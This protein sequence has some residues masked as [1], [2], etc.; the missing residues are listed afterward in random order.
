VS[1]GEDRARAREWLERQIEELGDLRNANPRDPSFK[2]WRQNTL[3]VLQRIWP[4]EQYRSERFRRITFSP[5]STKPAGQLVRDWFT[6]GCTEATEYLRSLIEE[7]D[8]V[9]TP[10]P[11]D[12]QS[13]APFVGA[14][15]DDDDERMLDLGTNAAAPAPGA[16]GTSPA[17]SIEDNVLDLGAP[18]SA[19]TDDAESSGP[20]RLK[21]EL[22]LPSRR[23]DPD[24]E[25]G[26]PPVASAPRLGPITPKTPAGPL[27]SAQTEV[28]KNVEPPPGIERTPVKGSGQT[29]SRRG[30]KP[31]AR[32]L[33]PKGKLKNLLGLDYLSPALDAEFSAAPIA[34]TPL[35]NMAPPKPAPAP[36]MDVTPAPA[37]D[38]TPAPAMDVTPAPAETKP[39]PPAAVTPPAPAP[40]ISRVMPK[41]A[42]PAPTAAVT[43]TP[44][45]TP[46]P[47]PPAPPTPPPAPPAAEPVAEEPAPASTTEPANSSPYDADVLSRATEDFMR[48]SP[49]FG[50]QGRP[51]QRATDVTS[52]LD[53][54]AVAVATLAGDLTRLG[55]P[56]AATGDLRAALLELA[57]QL[58][59]GQPTWDALSVAVA[60]S[61]A[62]PDLARRLLPVLL[63]W[64]ERAA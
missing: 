34:S 29:S 38:V 22:R 33:A 14:D 54:D 3:T 42:V 48:N 2:L 8:I 25:V 41:P 5:A 61:M 7:I 11:S 28:P 9:G 45:P 1:N 32:K 20:P 56:D 43:P 44:A 46:K 27:I 58:D 35:P 51:V 40:P 16:P 59:A 39:A 60:G 13:S 49:V 31:R 55:V 19:E 21:V 26:A 12:G 18:A 52:F 6:R 15:P 50:L 17:Y 63:P 47:A 30:N 57:S 10:T 37:M 64:L 53:P 4:S 24:A 23:P 62:F 36:A